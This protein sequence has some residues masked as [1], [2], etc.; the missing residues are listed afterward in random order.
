VLTACKR[1]AMVSAQRRT[2]PTPRSLFPCSLS[3]HAPG[4]SST[5]FLLSIPSLSLAPR[6]GTAHTLRR[7]VVAQS[8]GAPSHPRRA[9][10][11]TGHSAV[12]PHARNTNTYTPLSNVATTSEIGRITRATLLSFAAHPITCIFVAKTI[13]I[14]VL[15]WRFFLL[16]I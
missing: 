13:S 2:P 15:T 6:Y 1:E 12:S 3:S 10:P 11:H 7:L 16:Q 8:R 5:N 9:S 4:V 14:L